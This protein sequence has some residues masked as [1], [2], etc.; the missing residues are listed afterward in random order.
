[1]VAAKKNPYNNYHNDKVFTASNE[2]LVLMLYD[3]ALKF[4]NVAI[5]AL[6]K[7]P[8]DDYE[9]AAEAI[10]RV[11]KIIKE[12]QV[13]LDRQY[14]ISD[15]LY[16][17]YDYLFRRLVQASLRKEIPILE[18]IRDM[19]RELRDTWKEAMKIAKSEGS[20]STAK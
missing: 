6:E 7:D 15:E 13:T 19:I 9:K 2:E 14:T 18:E 12:F 16:N 11:Q 8:K 1:M 4:T 10:I 3:G 20:I 5:M 17:I